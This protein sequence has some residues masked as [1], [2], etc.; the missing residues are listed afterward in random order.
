MSPS[1]H[2][3]RVAGFTLIELMV[4][5]V[6]GLIITGAALA[7]L[8]TNR[9]T[10]RATESLDRIQEN[11][12]TAFELMARDLREGAGNACG[13]TSLMTK[14][15]VVNGASGNWYTDWT[16]GIQGYDGATATPGLAF[17]TAAG[18]RVNGTDAIDIRS[19]TSANVNVVPDPGGNP[20]EIKVSTNAHGLVPG[21]IAVACDPAHMAVF[22]VTGANAAN[23]TV[24][25]NTGNSNPSPGNCS[26][27][28]GG[29]GVPLCTTNGNAYKFGCANGDET[30]C[31]AGQQ[32]PAV[33]AKLSATRWY[34]G[35]NDH[36]TRSLFHVTGTTVGGNA[37]T[38]TDEVAEG[39]QD[40]QL[41]YLVDGTSAYQDAGSIAAANWQ[42]ESVIAVRVV[43]TVTDS[44][45][46]GTDG[47]APTRILEHTVNFRNRTP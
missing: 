21:D 20:A 17:G 34:V 3:R 27:G 39:V 2:A 12:R 47:Q 19:S 40:M 24:V 6:L 4:S 28:L 23:V 26:K 41:Q 14:V 32:W 43:L 25:H 33:L 31:G 7:V 36:G 45:K 9:Q 46:S 10:Y 5:L 38:R 42:N 16:A 1:R 18:A 44:D 15:N 8:M 11:A 13:K 22:Q 35:Y 30:N 37:A 29:D